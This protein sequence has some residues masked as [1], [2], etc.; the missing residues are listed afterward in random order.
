MGMGEGDNKPEHSN[1]Y[2]SNSLKWSSAE[3]PGT[4]RSP[5]SCP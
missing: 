1:L 4:L 3:R 5:V 2:Q